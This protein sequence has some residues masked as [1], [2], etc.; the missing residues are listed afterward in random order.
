M[1]TELLLATIAPLPRSASKRMS[2]FPTNVPFVFGRYNPGALELRV[3]IFKIEKTNGVMRMMQAPFTPAHGDAFAAAMTYATA[4]D[5][6]NGYSPGVNPFARYQHVGQDAFY[7]A[8]SLETAKVALSLAMRMSGAS[9]GLLAQSHTRPNQTITKSGGWLKKTVTTTVEGWTKPEWFVGTPSQ[10]QPQGVTETICAIDVADPSLCP[11]Y[12]AVPSDV[13]WSQWEGG[14]LPSFED[15]TST[16][17]E[18]KSSYTVLAWMVVAFHCR[19]RGSR[20]KPRSLR[21]KL[22]SRPAG[23][24]LCKLWSRATRRLR[25]A[26]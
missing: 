10:F 5:R 17:S 19:Y 25:D 22:R 7:N 11:K 16:Y 8:G 26:N 14:N 4:A 18:S 13:A 2:L 6:A 12:L 9:I 1:G 20:R 23:E 15:M 24:R 3:D 21:G